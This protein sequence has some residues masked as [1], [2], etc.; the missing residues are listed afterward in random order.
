MKRRG[1]GKA[2]GASFERDVC[3]KLSLWVSDGKREDLYWRSAMSGGRATLGHRKGKDLRHQAGDICAVHPEGHKLTERF[4]IECKHY[5][6]LDLGGLLFKK[7]KL[8]NFWVATEA[9]ATKHERLP[10]LIAKQ[11]N[12]KTLVLCEPEKFPG[13]GAWGAWVVI[14]QTIAFELG[15]F[16]DMLKCPFS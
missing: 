4:Y 7:G 2:K 15:Y 1:G 14:S 13:L 9:E 12:F 6:D 16:E 8:F 5:R 11:N 10:L 3:K